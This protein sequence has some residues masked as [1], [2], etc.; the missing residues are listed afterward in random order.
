[1]SAHRKRVLPPA[2]AET[3]LSAVRARRG[4]RC[5]SANTLLAEHDSGTDGLSCV[6][7]GWSLFWPDARARERE[8]RIVQQ[9][10]DEP[11]PK[12]GRPPK[13]RSLP[14]PPTMTEIRSQRHDALLVDLIAHFRRYGA[15]VHP[16]GIEHT[17]TRPQAEKLGGEAPTNGTA[18]FVRHQ[19]DLLVV[20]PNPRNPDKARVW[21]V[22]AKTWS[23]KSDT[24]PNVALA[25]HGLTTLRLLD[26]FGCDVVAVFGHEA[27]VAC[28]A[29]QI[30]PVSEERDPA[31]LA[32]AKRNGG[33]GEPW[34]LVP[35]DAPYL[36]PLESFLE[37]EMGQ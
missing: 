8:A 15:R 18:L 17:L 7:C 34:V 21:L 5:A 16:Y 12:R 3:V 26:A 23:P 1:V 19:P 37:R 28:W 22:E 33:S 25:L 29:R 30:S 14:M 9:M 11:L 24:S 27:P 10:D 35:K 31:K 2:S 20:Q 6:L 36:M 4:P 13:R 32:E